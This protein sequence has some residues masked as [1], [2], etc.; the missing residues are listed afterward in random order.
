VQ[1]KQKEVYLYRSY[2]SQGTPCQLQY[3]PLHSSHM[4]GG[5]LLPLLSFGTEPLRAAAFFLDN[6]GEGWWRMVRYVCES[7]KQNAQTK[8][9]LYLKELES[10][11]LQPH[12]CKLECIPVQYIP[13]SVT[14]SL[15]H[16]SHGEFPGG[17]HVKE[18]KGRYSLPWHLLMDTGCNRASLSHLSPKY[19]SYHDIVTGCRGY[20][21]ACIKQFMI[22]QWAPADHVRMYFIL[23]LNVGGFS[24]LVVQ[25]QVGYLLLRGIQLFSFSIFNLFSFSLSKSSCVCVCILC[26]YFLCVTYILVW[27]GMWVC[28]CVASTCVCAHVDRD[29]CPCIKGKD[30]TIY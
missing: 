10:N 14:L 20:I 3:P 15:L 17:F 13:L 2:Q 18:G 21:H 27:C 5:P 23:E 19:F 1:G 16:F 4:L 8:K 22:T 12:S 7:V 11:E 25:M 30:L 29:V 9:L 28:M 24:V 6:C 26:V